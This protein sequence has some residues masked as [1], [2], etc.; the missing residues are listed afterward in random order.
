MDYLFLF[1]SIGIPKV[2][3]FKQGDDDCKCKQFKILHISHSHPRN[4]NGKFYCRISLEPSCV[5]IIKSTMTVMS[6]G[7]E[8]YCLLIAKNVQQGH[9]F[10][11]IN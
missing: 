2:A 3:R 9:Q 10:T 7:R 5:V 8:S 11:H 1:F 6:F 4:V